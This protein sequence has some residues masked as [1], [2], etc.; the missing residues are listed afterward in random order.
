MKI[1]YY[2]LKI[3][4]LIKINIPNYNFSARL[5]VSAILAIAALFGSSKSLS[6]TLTFDDLWTMAKTNSEEIKKTKTETE[7]STLQATRLKNHWT[8]SL[9]LRGGHMS[10]NNAGQ[11][12]FANMNQRSVDPTSDFNPRSVNNPG[13][14]HLTEM[15]MGLNWPLYEGGKFEN[16]KKS[17]QEQLEAQRFFESGN[18]LKLKSQLL[19]SYSKILNYENSLNE[20]NRTVGIINQQMKKY[21]IGNKKNPIGHSGLL[22]LRATLNKAIAYKGQILSRKR[23]EFQ[24][25]QMSI[26]NLQT[27]WRPKQESPINFIKTNVKNEDNNS[28]SMILR[29]QEH[30]NKA[31]TYEAESEKS[32]RLPIIG[33]YAESSTFVGERDTA[34]SVTYGAYLKWQFGWYNTHL[35]KE[36]HLKKMKNKYELQVQ[37]RKEESGRINLKNWIISLGQTLN[38]TLENKKII[39]EQINISEQ[40]YKNGAI[41]AIQLNQIYSSL[42][43]LQ[44]EV[45]QVISN[46]IEAETQL[47]AISSK[48]E[49]I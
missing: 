8:P 29:G 41:N 20:I 18:E 34:N 12:L 27:K 40:L 45:E 16:L 17:S 2:F 1:Y 24:I 38:T 33:A 19:S 4:S 36:I 46:I 44:I 3:K 49:R 37:K 30:L 32:N 35:H 47:Y 23:Q 9:Y 39:E 6:N 43:D 31:M 10:T 5:F 7:I 48:E 22:G 25:I 28:P 13:Q 26:P 21:Q 14:T 42:V 15:T 11:A